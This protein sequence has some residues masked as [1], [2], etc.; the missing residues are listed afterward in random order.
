MSTGRENPGKGQPQPDKDPNK[1]T[2]DKK[3]GK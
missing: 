3:Q 2:D 1:N